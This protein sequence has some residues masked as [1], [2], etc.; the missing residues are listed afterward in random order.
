[1]AS[2]TEDSGQ[3]V[4]GADKTACSRTRLL[5]V[6]RSAGRRNSRP[7]RWLG[8]AAVFLLAGTPAGHALEGCAGIY[9]TSR[10]KPLP[11]S[12]IVKL[13]RHDDSARSGR[14]ADA[15]VAGLAAAGIA[16]R[17]D[18]TVLLHLDVAVSHPP[19]PRP[20][21]T[22]PILPDLRAL[23][24]GPILA[25]PDTDPGRHAPPIHPG[26][27]PILLLRTELTDARA[28]TVLWIG[29]FSCALR[30]SS[31]DE[32]LAHDLGSVVGVALGRTATRVPF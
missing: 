17:G 23:Q 16:V 6:T 18:P 29:E 1:M 15:F 11:S 12:V 7:G 32:Q 20:R 21:A 27:A 4:P 19:L 24:S 8:L 14:L 13:D 28:G 30:S 3:R 31:E 22:G 2:T 9:S 25:L 10:L 5:F 26:D